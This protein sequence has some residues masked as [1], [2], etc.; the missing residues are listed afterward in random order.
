MYRLLDVQ[1]WQAS[2]VVS[3]S[4]LIIFQN[5]Q[6]EICVPYDFQSKHTKFL[7]PLKHPNFVNDL[8]IIASTELFLLK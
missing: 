1:I 6:A 2:G 8:N 4:R 3:V 5:A 7:H